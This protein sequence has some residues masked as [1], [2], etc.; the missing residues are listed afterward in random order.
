MYDSINKLI[1]DS[2]KMNLPLWKVIQKE[3]CHEENISEEESFSLMKKMYEAMKSS[4]KSY[5][6]KLRSRSGLV[7]GEAGKIEKNNTDG[8][9]DRFFYFV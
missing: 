7:G 9:T 8:L 3:D 6:P 4:E 2:Q 5:N 1:E